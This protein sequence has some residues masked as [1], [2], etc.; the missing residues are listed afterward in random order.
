VVPY[1]RASGIEKLDTLIVSHRDKD[2]AGGLVAVQ[3][4]LPVGRFLT[5]IDG[6]SGE[7]CH[8]GQGWEWDGV[9]FTMLHPLAEDYALKSM[10]PNNLSC[11][12][13]VENAAGSVLL[14]G[15]IEARDEKAL[16]ARSPQRLPSTVLVV[17]H[18]GGMGSSTPDF[19]AAVGAREAIFSAGYR[20]AFQHPRPQVLARHAASRTWRT[21][22]EGAL[23]IALAGATELS[24]WRR[25]HRRY[26]HKQ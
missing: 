16:L 8:D 23:H 22:R 5:S 14:A 15:D 18:H 13:R 26:W 21:D 10:R 2:H 4:A 11:V 1:L 25:E 7:P 12:L 19:I 6:I 24:G 17:P 20:N 9:R 3:S